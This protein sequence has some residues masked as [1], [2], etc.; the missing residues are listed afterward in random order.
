MKMRETSRAQDKELADNNSLYIGSAPLTNVINIRNEEP[1]RIKVIAAST[2]S[3]KH[4]EY[5][6][7]CT[8]AS[9][10]YAPSSEDIKNFEFNGY[11]YVNNPKGN[12]WTEIYAP[13][14][15]NKG[16][17][18]VNPETGVT[19]IEDLRQ[20]LSEM[21]FVQEVLAEFGEE[22]MGLYKDKYVLS[23]LQ[24]GAR[25]DHKYTTDMTQ[26]ELMTFLKKNPPTIKL[27]G[28][29]WD[30]K[31]NKIS[32]YLQRKKHIYDVIKYLLESPLMV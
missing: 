10:R 4:E 26:A 2:P 7:W 8:G 3:G 20:E 16:L 6:K 1:E 15:V 11:Q 12:G 17:L 27:L 31:Y 22:E 19:Y 18:K 30:K 21:R 24:E 25:I 32:I 29:D 23:A 14:I 9:H 13:S 28:V 5:Y